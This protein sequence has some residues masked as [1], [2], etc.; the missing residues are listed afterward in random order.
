MFV[1]AA[2]IGCQFWLHPCRFGFSTIVHLNFI[3]YVNAHCSGIEINVG[4]GLGDGV[5]NEVGG[6]YVPARR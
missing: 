4:I 1:V 5:K 3:I 2:T 6:D